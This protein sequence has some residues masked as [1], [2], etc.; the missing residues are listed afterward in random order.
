MIFVYCGHGA[1]G[2]MITSNGK[3][4]SVD[5][6]SKSFSKAWMRDVETIPR[7]FIID[8]QR[9]KAS[10]GSIRGMFKN[11]TFSDLRYILCCDGIGDD[12]NYF[13]DILIDCVLHNTKQNKA[14]F[15]M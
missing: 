13:S 10:K 6:L 5:N 12:N 4:L 2:R 3:K 7:L 9:S 15:G 1:N 8:C 11:L 14:P